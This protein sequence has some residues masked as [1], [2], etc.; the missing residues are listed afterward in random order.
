MRKEESG[1]NPFDG[2]AGN[3][4]RTPNMPEIDLEAKS[5]LYELLSN[6]GN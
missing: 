4:V 2:F 1:F 3:Y 5:N 6:I